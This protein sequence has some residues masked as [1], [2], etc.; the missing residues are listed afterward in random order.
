MAYLAVTEG[1]FQPALVHFVD[2]LTT[3]PVLVV[4]K[5]SQVGEVTELLEICREYITAMRLELA[6]K[7]TQDAV[8]QAQLSA[9]FT[10]CR[11]QPMHVVLGLRV[12]IKSTFAA[13]AYKTCASLCQRVLELCL[14]NSRSNVTKAVNPTQIKGI[15]KTC[16]E[17]AP[18]ESVDIKY[19][20]TEAFNLCC[21]SFTPLTKQLPSVRCPFCQSH[22]RPQNEGQLCKTC[23]LSKIGAEATGL[24]VF[25]G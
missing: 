12:A 24:R 6:R 25:N 8:R 23:N 20:D 15:L 7:D 4:D 21:E 16:S 22:Y 14:T 18:A 17:K 11:L 5:K 2:I 19:S 13:K 3:I 10:R 9:Y 1:K